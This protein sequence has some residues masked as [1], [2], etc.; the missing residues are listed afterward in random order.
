MSQNIDNFS[1]IFIKPPYDKLI[2]IQD[3]PPLISALQSL[4]TGFLLLAHGR[5]P[6]ALAN[7]AT[8]IESAAKAQ[9]QLKPDDKFNLAEALPDLN[10]RIPKERALPLKELKRFREKRNQ[11]THYGYSSR[12]DEESVQLIFTV[13][14]PFIDAWIEHSMGFS[15]ID[16]LQ[17]DLA[18]KVRLAMELIKTQI[19]N[20]ITAVNAIRGVVKL[21]Q[22]LTRE[23]YMTWWEYEILE[24]DASKI[25]SGY[26]L[27]S[28]MIFRYQQELYFGSATAVITCP[29]C[30]AIESLVVK[31]DDEQL[32]NN[33]QLVLLEAHCVDCELNLPE[34]SKTLLQQLCNHQL[35]NDL[36]DIALKEF[37][38]K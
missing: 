2:E 35:T 29:I 4:D 30:D 31:L 7:F 38:I 25:G 28:N 20:P 9:L 23:S 36:R 33:K 6:H 15:L 11:I 3:K 1:L 32:V 17:K 34:N 26:E 18:E 22:Y 5:Y 10:F 19:N 13:A 14:L 24:Q 12:D 37:G 16:A 8:A 21:I 27:K